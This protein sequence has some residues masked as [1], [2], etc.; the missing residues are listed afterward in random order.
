MMNYL[1]TL[2]AN[3]YFKKLL[4]EEEG[5]GTIEIII[6]LAV[7]VGLALLFKTFAVELF[8]NFKDQIDSNSINIMP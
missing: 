6:I 8:N 3:V 1:N 5:L 7:L 2:Y 4:K